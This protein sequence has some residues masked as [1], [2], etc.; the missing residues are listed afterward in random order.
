[1]RFLKTYK[2]LN[3][4]IGYKARHIQIAQPMFLIKIASQKA[5]LWNWQDFKRPRCWRLNVWATQYNSLR[6][7]TGH[8][9]FTI[10]IKSDA[11]WTLKRIEC[12]LSFKCFSAN[13]Q[14]NQLNFIGYNLEVSSS[15]RLLI[16]ARIL[17]QMVHFNSSLLLLL[18][19]AIFWLRLETWQWDCFIF[20]CR[21]V[22]LSEICL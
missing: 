18:K 4:P 2:T 13:E 19:P 10:S 5:I 15:I 17:L 22:F 12:T 20:L 1:M 7:W 14:K 11:I 3:S 21:S 6:Q 8:Y 16:H 9:G